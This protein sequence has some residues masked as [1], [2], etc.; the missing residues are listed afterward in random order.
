MK[1]RTPNEREVSELVI[2]ANSGEA[3]EKQ[4]ARLDEL[5]RADSRL[6][7]HAAQMLDQLAAL[8]WQGSMNG[9][10]PEKSACETVANRLAADS[11]RTTKT[12]DR[13]SAAAR[14]RWMWLTV[15]AGIG[16]VIGGLTAATIYRETMAN[17]AA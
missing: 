14:R 11:L 15:A 9:I 6:V 5:I 13:N 8:A 16:F 12:I 1:R 17:S 3:D 10:L 7:N 2:A 4:L